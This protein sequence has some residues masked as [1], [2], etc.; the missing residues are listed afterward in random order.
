MSK[1]TQAQDPVYPLLDCEQTSPRL[2]LFNTA[3]LEAT[4]VYLKAMGLQS[5]ITL[6]LY[7][8]F[9]DVTGYLLLGC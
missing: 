4:M 7:K 1:A 8:L 3:S 6:V 9:A 2:Q 5:D